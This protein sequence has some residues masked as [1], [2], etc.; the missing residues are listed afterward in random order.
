MTKKDFKGVAH[1]I[2]GSKV[3]SISDFLEPSDNQSAP[4]PSQKHDIGSSEKAETTAPPASN[5]KQLSQP[6]SIK[7]SAP[8]LSLK[9]TV[10]P[11]VL[12]ELPGPEKVRLSF[13]LST[14]I[15]YELDDLKTAMRRM[16]PRRDLSKISKSSIV[17]AAISLVSEDIKEKGLKSRFAKMILEK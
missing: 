17:E 5:E 6:D 14:Q 1:G 7:E 15:T 8:Q 2:L 11:T 16:A 12:D 10:Q 9:E 4:E 13:Y 3:K